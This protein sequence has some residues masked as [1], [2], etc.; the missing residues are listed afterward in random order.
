[1]NLDLITRRESAAALEI[2]LARRNDP[3]LDR[4]VEPTARRLDRCVRR[5][6]D[7]ILSAAGIRNEGVVVS[8]QLLSNAMTYGLTVEYIGNPE[9]AAIKGRR[10]LES[11]D[12]RFALRPR[13]AVTALAFRCLPKSGHSQ[14]RLGVRT[15]R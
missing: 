7:R 11:S 1:M 6:G 13:L 12:A 3:A 10:G 8:A 9:K 4:E 2:H 15:S 14:G 5:W